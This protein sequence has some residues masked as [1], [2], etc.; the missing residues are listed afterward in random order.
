MATSQFS[1]LLKP[2]DDESKDFLEQ[3]KIE[4]EIVVRKARIA[5]EFDKIKEQV[6]FSVPFLKIDTQGN[7]YAVAEG[8]GLKLCNFVGIQ[9]ELA[10]KRLYTGERR[11]YETVEF[12][13][14]KGFDLTA[15]I[16]NHPRQF[17]RLVE[18]DGIFYNRSFH[19]H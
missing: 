19:R 5:D 6:G 1:S 12:L 7:D 2:R 3:N 11:Y 18:V 4:K 16:H 10:V 17:P 13:A 14:E 15:F 9:S 8:A